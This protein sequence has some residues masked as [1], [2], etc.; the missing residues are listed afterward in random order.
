MTP[1][2]LRRMLAKVAAHAA[3]IGTL[4]DEAEAGPPEGSVF[5][6]VDSRAAGV[7]ADWVSHVALRWGPQLDLEP[8]ELALVLADGLAQ[9]RR[10]AVVE[11]SPTGLL[12]ITL[13]EGPPRTRPGRARPDVPTHPQRG[14]RRGRDA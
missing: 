7:V 3:R 1:E 6:P 8:R 5:R 10:V 13:G 11:V 14:G 2:E 4:P 9:R 12:A